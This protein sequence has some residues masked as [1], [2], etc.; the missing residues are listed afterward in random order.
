MTSPKTR[1]RKGFYPS[2][3]IDGKSNFKKFYLIKNDGTSVESV[4]LNIHDKKV[5][6]ELILIHFLRFYVK[7]IVQEDGGINIL[8]R[9][10]PWDF[11]L[12]LFGKPWFNVEIISISDNQ[13]AFKNNT[14]EETIEAIT[15]K[16]YIR[17]RD[18]EKINENIPDLDADKKIRL[19]NNLGVPKDTLIPNPWQR[20]ELRAFISKLPPPNK[21]LY[22]M[23]HEALQKKANK[24]HSHK[25]NTVL[26]IDNRTIACDSDDFEEVLNRSDELCEQSP[27]LEMW[28]Y[29]GYYSDLDGTNAGWTL[30]PIC[31]SLETE[32]TL[33][34]SM[35]ENGK[36]LSSDAAKHIHWNDGD[37]D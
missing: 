31:L 9:D 5:R 4:A 17:I 14:R 23:I 8:S 35:L 1:T 12:E 10:R 11:K 27:F 30:N 34:K 20:E 22:E 26:I 13:Q 28:F 18:L 24:R 15:G 3:S 29:T 2:E 36:D 19:F 6:E 33:V 37:T 7:S 16:K 25:N 32:T 21:N